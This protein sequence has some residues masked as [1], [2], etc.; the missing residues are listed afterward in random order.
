MDIRISGSGQICSG[1]YDNIQISGSGRLEGFV[2]CTSLSISGTVRTGD[3]ACSTNVTICGSAHFEGN[4]EAENLSVSGSLHCNKNVTVNKQLT[5]SGSAH[6]DGS[7]KCGTLSVSGSFSSNGDIEA[8]IVNI[9]GKLNCK[10]LVNAEEITIK[11]H[12][13]MTIGSIGGSHVLIIPENSKLK[14]WIKFPWFFST[15]KEH[16]NTV[17]VKNEIEGD[18]IE[19]E[20]V[21]SPRVSGRTVTIG[22]NCI[23]DLVQYSEQIKVSPNAKVGKTEKI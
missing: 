15:G 9:I 4:I 10:G 8:E 11:S 12:Q 19:L 23:I 16:V 20:N 21:V 22:E 2:H 18:Q 1:E 6:G 14:S 5:C 7:V 17:H 3:V 13:S